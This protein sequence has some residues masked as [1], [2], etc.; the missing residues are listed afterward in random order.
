MC[1]KMRYEELVLK[2]VGMGMNI[3]ERLE[4]RGPAITEIPEIQFQ[5]VADHQTLSNEQL[6]QLRTETSVRRPNMT[7]WEDREIQWEASILRYTCL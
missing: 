1:K 7:T 2:N 4:T 6:H 5:F 3:K